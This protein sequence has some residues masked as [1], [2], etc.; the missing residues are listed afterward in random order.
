MW[1]CEVHPIVPVESTF[2]LTSSI[3]TA[4]PL[5]ELNSPTYLRTYG[6]NSESY[7]NCAMRS[8]FSIINGWQVRSHWI[9][10]P[11]A[12][13]VFFVTTRN[14]QETS[15][16]GHGHIPSN[17]PRDTNRYINMLAHSL[18]RIRRPASIR[19]PASRMFKTP[20]VGLCRVWPL[21]F[22][23]SP[24]PFNEHPRHDDQVQ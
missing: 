19:G 23:I 3:Y 11:Y 10:Y 18:V 5:N 24:P 21:I 12:L 13:T 20:R 16:H 9:E 7:I 15:A 1:K 8:R 2:M 6:L 17:K 22:H 14:V 4:L